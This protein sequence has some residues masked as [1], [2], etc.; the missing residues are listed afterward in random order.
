MGSTDHPLE[1]VIG[2][3][4]QS[5]RTRR[6]LETDGEMCM[7]ALIVSRTE[8]KNIKEAM[9][10]SA[11]IEA[12]QEEIHH[13]SGKNKPDEENIVIRNKARLVAKGYGQQEGIDFKESFAPVARLEAVWLFIVY[14][15]HKSFPVYQMDVKTAFLNGP[16]KEEAHVNQ[17]DG[18]VDPHHPKKVYRLK[19]ALYGLKQAPRAW[20]D[21][22]SNFLVSKGFSKGGD[23][24]V[25]WS[26]KKQDCTSMTLAEA[27]VC[28]FI[29]VLRS[30]SMVENSEHVEKGIV[31]LFFVG[32]EYQLAD[33][34]TKALSEDR[35]KYLMDENKGKMPTKVELTLEQSQQG[36]SDYVLIQT[37]VLQSCTSEV[38]F[39]TTY[40][41][42]S[43]Q[44][45]SFSIKIVDPKLPQRSSKSNQESA[46]V[47]QESQIKM[48][49]VKEMMQDK[50]L[51]NSKSKDKG[52]R[53]R[54]QSMNEQSHYKQ[55]KTKTR[56]KKAK[57]KRGSHIRAR[58]KDNSMHLRS[59]GNQLVTSTQKEELLL[60][61]RD[62]DILYKFK[63]GDF[64]RLWI[65]D[66]E[67][68]LLLLVQGKLTNLNVEERLA[69]NVSLRMFT[70][71]VVIQRR[72]EDLQLG[73]ESYQKE[74]NLIK[75]DTYISNLRRRDAYTP[76]SDPRG[77]NYQNKDKK[78][79][80]M[81]IDELHK[82]SDGT[83]GD[84]RTALNDRLK[85]I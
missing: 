80:L 68:M 53:S 72:V 85:G 33:L 20:Y 44:S 27:E 37:S 26:S 61:Q 62:D 50:D 2:N 75:P 11:W 35:V 64:H 77:F 22:L 40:S 5:I 78:N 1:Q 28:V 29:C 30:S 63:E 81:R 73:V 25:S 59:Q 57:L 67:Y 19:K 3:P 32:T 42:S 4:S 43:F 51:K 54:S 65:Q 74:L 52:S 13:G 12:M 21:E 46:Q 24:L 82:F 48:I 17:P 47:D 39:I 23:K 60:S 69:F 31:E 16:L 83:L 36:V 10:D 45:Q 70:K 58:S 76:Y 38:G 34:F 6:Q 56:P 71:S 7:F 9:A 41:Y 8:P 79:R 49:Q 14:A 55:E 15:A 18:F 84:V 66:I